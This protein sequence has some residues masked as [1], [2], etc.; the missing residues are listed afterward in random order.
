MTTTFNNYDIVA[1]FGGTPEA[2]RKRCS[3]AI[4]RLAEELG[5]DQSGL[6]SYQITGR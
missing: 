4:D 5:L 3:R 6:V 1:E 2:M